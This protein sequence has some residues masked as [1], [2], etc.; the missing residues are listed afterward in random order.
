[1]LAR[2]QITS[3]FF[4]GPYTAHRLLG[5]PDIFEL[6]RDLDLH[7]TMT[8]NYLASHAS[9]FYGLRT[10]IRSAVLKAVVPDVDRLAPVFG[11]FA[12]FVEARH[13]QDTVDVFPIAVDRLG[14]LRDL[15]RAHGARF[16]L[17]LPPIG[18]A[19][20]RAQ[21]EDVVL[22][23]AAQAGVQVIETDAHDW[24]PESAFRDG[25]HMN[26]AGARRYTAELA[27]VLRRVV[28]DSGSGAP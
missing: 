2:Y 1:V 21:G 4:R 22:R 28:D 9:A 19:R 15:A 5:V 20:R 23:A 13:D 24:Y 27:D 12:P 7:P 26:D 10:E 3:D 25:L 6:S 17:I 8:S 14:R 16:V 18:P 11:G